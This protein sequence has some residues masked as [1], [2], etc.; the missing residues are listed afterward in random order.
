MRPDPV[1]MGGTM[2]KEWTVYILECGDGTLYTGITDDL[3]RR[4]KAHESGRGAKYTRGRGPLKLR[5]RE[6]VPDKSTALKRECA[7]KRLRKHEKIAIIHEKENENQNHLAICPGEEYTKHEE[8]RALCPPEGSENEMKKERTL[9][10]LAA[11]IGSRF[12]GGVKQLQSVGPSGEVIMDYSIHD[13]IEAGFNRVIFII[14]HDI[15]E[16]FDRIMGDRIR[17]ICVKKGVEVLCAYQEK[18]NL[19]GGF[20][21][22]ADRTKPWGT[23][24]ALLSCKG[25]LHGGFAVINADDYYG[26]DAYRRAIE[27]LDSLEERSKGT[28]GLIGFRLGNTLSEHGGVTRGLCRSH[29]GWLTYIRETKNII[30]TPTGAVAEIDGEE[31]HL[32]EEVPV[33]MNMWG[34]TPDVLDKLEERFIEF[35]GESLHDPK[36]EFL[37]PSEMGVLLSREAVR[38]RVLPTTSQ[39]FGMTYAED[40]PGVRKAFADMTEQ[41]IYTEPLF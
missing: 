23:G 35:L 37:I 2:E 39:W 3:E 31:R 33:S 7:L 25:M 13:A 28:Y 36:S 30:K 12:A 9:V 21:C 19:P 41:G 26:K 11:G 22:P 27:F 5:Y 17:A 8:V 15:Q 38:I 1:F 32:N 29:N 40:M 6:T 34:F 16:L 14:R 10:V 24:H 18:T 4:L 20:A